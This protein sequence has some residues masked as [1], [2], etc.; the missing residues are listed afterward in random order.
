MTLT[1]PRAT[2]ASTDP[3]VE[4]SATGTRDAVLDVC[5]RAREA[6]RVLATARRTT[7]DAALHAVADALVANTGRI[8]AANVED[9]DRGER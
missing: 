7:K 4:P 9:L 2:A 6:A 3:A 8:V 1:D 5:R